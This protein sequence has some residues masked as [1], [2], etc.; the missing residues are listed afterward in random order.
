MKK[1]QIVIIVETTDDVIFGQVL[2][3]E[4]TNY[5]YK[6]ENQ[7]QWSGSIPDNRS[8]LFSN[9]SGSVKQFMMKKG[10]S[11]SFDL[12]PDDHKCLMNLGNNEIK[13]YKKTN[14][15]Q[16]ICSQQANS[17]YDYREE[18]KA[19]AGCT[20]PDT[21]TVRKIIVYQLK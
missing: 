3:A 21:F 6:K 14:A 4:I 20:A 8:F 18:T 9:A 12:W 7:K 16:S 10:R 1:K 11:K 17:S 15:S 2:F 19:I 5:L 13:I